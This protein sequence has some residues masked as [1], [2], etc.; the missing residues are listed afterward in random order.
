MY[1]LQLLSAS[2]ST[3]RL[4]TQTKTTPTST[5]PTTPSSSAGEGFAGR[6]RGLSY[7]SEENPKRRRS[8]TYTSRQSGDRQP[9]KGLRHFSQRVCE[10]VRAKGTTTYNEVG[11]D[12][13]LLSTITDC[14]VFPSVCACIT[15]CTLLYCTCV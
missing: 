8:N 13:M 9:N 5:L 12:I 2:S 14:V 7:G 10:K 3:G 6:K 11:V 1:F 4:P 15:E